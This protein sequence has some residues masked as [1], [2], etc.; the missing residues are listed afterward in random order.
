MWLE[1]GRMDVLGRLL[2]G[3]NEQCSASGEMS[4]IKARTRS[5]LLALLRVH[6]LALGVR[7]RAAALGRRATLC[8]CLVFRIGILSRGS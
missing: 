5:L 2:A 6:V 3:H 8:G 4:N 1:Q 7:T